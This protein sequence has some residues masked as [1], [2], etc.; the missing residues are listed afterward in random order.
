MEDRQDLGRTG[1]AHGAV[2][3]SGRPDYPLTALDY[4]KDV[5]NLHAGTVAVDLGAGTGIFS[6][7]I[8]PF[9]GALVAV[10]PSE[11]MRD[12]FDRLTPGIEVV[13]GH[14][15]S[16]PLPDAS[17]NVVFVAQ[18]FHWFTLPDALLEIHRV[19]TPAGQLALI[20]NERDESVDWVQELS[21]A[22]QWNTRQPYEVGRDFTG[23]LLTGP[24]GNVERHE[25]KH[26]QL[27]DHEGLFVRVASTSYLT[28]MEA[29]ERVE[30]MQAVIKVV[31]ALPETVELPY[32]TTTY[33][34]TSLT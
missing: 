29:S 5:L 20:W 23:D 7:Q 18:A 8:R 19:L 15:C 26:S 13:A 27:L 22:M 16:I 12:E 3:S 25:F 33:V 28:T 32:C 17:A 11:S 14:D 30:I 24:F 21:L 1:F 10:E 31:D 2:Y 34:A 4:F 6:R 9:L